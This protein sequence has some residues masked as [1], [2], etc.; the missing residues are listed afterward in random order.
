[1]LRSFDKNILPIS[2][3]QQNMQAMLIATKQREEKNTFN[4]FTQY[5]L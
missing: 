2:K 5:P 3:T 1:M 4:V